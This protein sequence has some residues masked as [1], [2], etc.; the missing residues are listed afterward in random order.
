MIESAAT[1]L[2][3]SPALSASP[4]LSS[5]R[6]SASIASV[7][8]ALAAFSHHSRASSICPT[9]VR[10]SASKSSSPGAYSSYRRKQPS[11]EGSRS[12]SRISLPPERDPSIA[13][14]H[15]Q[16]TSTSTLVPPQ[17]EALRADHRSASPEE[18]V[19]S[20]WRTAISIRPGRLG[21]HEVAGGTES[22]GTPCLIRDGASYAHGCFAGRQR[23]PREHEG[24]P[25]RDGRHV[26]KL[27]SRTLPVELDRDAEDDQQLPAVLVVQRH[28]DEKASYPGP[29]RVLEPVD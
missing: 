22:A 27:Q 20:R 5:I 1:S 23:E 28:S 19:R 4:A 6:D 7:L 8:P 21:R 16:G 12:R 29:D 15:R 24:G 3:C 26:T 10:C 14:R 2:E 9:S 13:H 25:G 11:E 17:N 18:H